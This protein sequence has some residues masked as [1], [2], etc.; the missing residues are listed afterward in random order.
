MASTTPRL[1]T[2]RG[3]VFRLNL[4]L[5]NGKGPERKENGKEKERPTH[6]KS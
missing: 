6:H 1:R 3:K 4:A 2:S 5:E